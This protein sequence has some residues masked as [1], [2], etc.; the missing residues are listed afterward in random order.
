M[1][2]A[3]EAE[4][5]GLYINAQAAI[6]ERTT[7]EVL[8]HPQPPTPLRTNNSTADGIINGT[9]KQKRSK[10]LDMRFYWLKDRAS[11]GQF[12]IYWKPA[13]RTARPL[14]KPTTSTRI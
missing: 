1:S 10:A 14:A 7:L 9:I 4:V 5:G 6:P 3:A 2:S 12:R 8:G 13:R 11:Q